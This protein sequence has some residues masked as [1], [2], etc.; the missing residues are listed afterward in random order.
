MKYKFLHE[1]MFKFLDF[2]V[3]IQRKQTNRK[4]NLKICKHLR[5]LPQ[6]LSGEES[7]CNA[8]EHGSISGLERSPEEGK[9]YPFQYF[10]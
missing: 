9:G 7:A 10:S 5:G 6:W 3:F 1:T 4:N 2:W 8:G